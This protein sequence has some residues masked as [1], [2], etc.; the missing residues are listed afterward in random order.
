MDARRPKGKASVGTLK[1]HEKLPS[2]MS[3]DTLLTY[4]RALELAVGKMSGVRF[5][6]GEADT[7]KLITFFDGPEAFEAERQRLRSETAS[8]PPRG[9]ALG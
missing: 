5:R 6:L 8:V 2:S 3:I 4:I 9:G 7:E 1:N